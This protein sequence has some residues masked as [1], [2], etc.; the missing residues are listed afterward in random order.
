MIFKYIWQSFFLVGPFVMLLLRNKTIF[1]FFR[2]TFNGNGS[3]SAE[4][5][6]NYVPW[7]NI[8]ELEHGAADRGSE[9]GGAEMGDVAFEQT[10][11]VQS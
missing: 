4:R 2:F 3:S 9:G 1:Q 6:H 7:L 10:L 5:I 8:G 11:L